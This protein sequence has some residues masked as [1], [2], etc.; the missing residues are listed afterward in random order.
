MPAHTVGPTLTLHTIFLS[1]HHFRSL[2]TGNDITGH[3]DITTSYQVTPEQTDQHQTMVTSQWC[4]KSDK[5]PFIINI[6]SAE[7]GAW[8]GGPK[9]S[10]WEELRE[11]TGQSTN[12]SHC[13]QLIL[14]SHWRERETDTWAST[15]TH[16]LVY[17]EWTCSHLNTGHVTDTPELQSADQPNVTHWMLIFIHT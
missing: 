14:R 4:H 3:C 12:R 6:V 5:L 7:G 13:P 8:R 1:V 11:A 2:K 17:R 9:G 10:L 15:L 16:R